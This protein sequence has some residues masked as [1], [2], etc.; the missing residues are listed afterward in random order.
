[1]R[2]SRERGR[3]LETSWCGVHLA[4]STGYWR[5]RYLVSRLCLGMKGPTRHS[6]AE[7]EVMHRRRCTSNSIDVSECLASHHHLFQSCM[8]PKTHTTGDVNTNSAWCGRWVLLALVGSHL[9]IVVHLCMPNALGYSG[10]HTDCEGDC[11]A[12]SSEYCSL[13]Y[14]LAWSIKTFLLLY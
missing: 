12:L 1:M 9:L 8:R 5:A 7:V 13:A 2:R 3:T 14:M 6:Y 10:V 4:V 11:L